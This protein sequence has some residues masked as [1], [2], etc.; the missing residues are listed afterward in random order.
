MT[1]RRRRM[2][3]DLQR[4]GLAPKTHPCALAAVH[5]LAQH[6]R[7][8]PDQLSAEERRQDCLVLLNAKQVAESPVRMHL[9]GIRCCYGR[10]LKRPWPVFDLVRPPHIHTR[11]SVWS[12]REVRSLLTLVEHPNARRCLRSIAA[13]GLRLTEGTPRQLSDIDAHRMRVRVQQGTGGKDRCVPL[14]PR[15]LA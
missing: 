6:D 9:S 14:A 12:L 2:R 4:R 10:T 15:V 3:E 8:A 1:T 7:R 11:P 13:C 5:Q